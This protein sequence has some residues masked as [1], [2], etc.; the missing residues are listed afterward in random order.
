MCSNCAID[1]LHEYHV[2][3]L[4]WIQMS[5]GGHFIYLLT[6]YPYFAKVISRRR[7]ELNVR[8]YKT[9]ACEA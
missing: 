4:N 1:L 9:F 7:I 6:R 3:R 5:H 8:K 2:D